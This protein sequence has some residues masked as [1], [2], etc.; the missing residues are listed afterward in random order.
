MEIL[1]NF[2]EWINDLLGVS[3]GG[4]L[5]INPVFIG[6]CVLIFVYAILTGQKFIAVAVFGLISGSLSYY[7]LYPKENVVQIYDLLVFL[8]V[9]GLIAIIMI[10]FAF[11]RE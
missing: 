5:V 1:T 6:F 8:A 4:E 9:M 7:Y 3:G 11:I 10:Y 2:F